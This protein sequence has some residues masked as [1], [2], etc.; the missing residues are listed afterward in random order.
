MQKK[1]LEQ[2]KVKYL[3]LIVN[4]ITVESRL[5]EV[6]RKSLSRISEFPR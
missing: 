3:Q 2:D 4:Y 6:V 5:T 1:F